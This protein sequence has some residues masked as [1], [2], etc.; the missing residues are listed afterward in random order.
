MAKKEKQPKAKAGEVTSQGFT[1][2]TK[3]DIKVGQHAP[4]LRGRDRG[5]GR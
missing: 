1:V 4:D 2:P 5:R 3:E